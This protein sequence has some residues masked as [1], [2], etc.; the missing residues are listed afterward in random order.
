MLLFNGPLLTKRQLSN[1]IYEPPNTPDPV[2]LLK[3]HFW[4]AYLLALLKI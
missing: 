1:E 3:L 2:L 4:N